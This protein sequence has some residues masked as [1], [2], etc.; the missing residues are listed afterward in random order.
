MMSVD[1]PYSLNILREKIF[2][3]FEIFWLTM[4]I[5]SLGDFSFKKEIL[6]IK[7]SVIH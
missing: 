3:D 2:T 7:F 6:V 4:K 5:L 1:I